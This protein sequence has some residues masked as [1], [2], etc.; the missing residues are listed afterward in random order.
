MRRRF[1]YLAMLAAAL[2][3]LAGLIEVGTRNRRERADSSHDEKR[4]TRAS[5]N[6]KV[7]PAS[8]PADR[9]VDLAA[10]PKPL[11]PAVLQPIQTAGGV[12]PARPAHDL[13]NEEILAHLQAG[14]RGFEVLAARLPVAREV[15]KPAWQ[16][17]DEWIVDTFYR[18]M[19]APGEPWSGPARWRF[20]IE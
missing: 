15:V 14:D 19:Q 6:D 7:G 2:L 4:A 13:T 10:A 5:S 20:R 18:Q 3:A 8:V 17:G 16:A 9:T 11:P 1:G 12:A